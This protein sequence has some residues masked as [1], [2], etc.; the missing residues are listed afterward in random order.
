M[1]NHHLNKTTTNLLGTL[2]RNDKDTI[3]GYTNQNKKQ[4][5]N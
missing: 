1:F 2:E 3:L 4:L 5:N